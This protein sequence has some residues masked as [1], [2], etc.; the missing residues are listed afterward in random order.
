MEIYIDDT[1]TYRT[2]SKITNKKNQKNICK[3][4]KEKQT[5]AD[6]SY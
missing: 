2:N 4:S 5:N 6:D 3:Q 1:P